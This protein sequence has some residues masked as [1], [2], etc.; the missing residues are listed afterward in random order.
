MSSKPAWSDRE[1]PAFFRRWR[2]DWQDEEL[3]PANYL[4]FKGGVRFVLAA[5]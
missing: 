5:A 1:L 3:S 2:T 4:D